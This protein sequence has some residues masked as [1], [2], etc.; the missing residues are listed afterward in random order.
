MDTLEKFIANIDIVNKEDYHRG[1]VTIFGTNMY[2]PRDLD[3]SLLNAIIKE[4]D[5]IG[6][7]GYVEFSKK[8]E[9]MY[10]N[11]N[12]DFINNY[13]NIYIYAFIKKVLI[14]ENNLKILNKL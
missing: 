8:Y 10:F 6:K 5:Q 12:N 2:I 7:N 1:V 9:F 13:V 3:T 11:N 4:T 14:F